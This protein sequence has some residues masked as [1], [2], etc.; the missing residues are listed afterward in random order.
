MKKKKEEFNLSEKRLTDLDETANAYYDE[1]W[2]KVFI[3]EIL[4]GLGDVVGDWR[5]E[6]LGTIESYSFRVKKMI[7]RKA[8]EKLILDDERSI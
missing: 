5:C 3:N 1:H 8:G 2:I 7:E 6:D 4:R